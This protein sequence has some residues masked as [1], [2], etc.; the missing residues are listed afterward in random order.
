M[1]QQKQNPNQKRKKKKGHTPA[2][3]NTFAFRHNAKSK[4][5]AKI[6]ASPNEGV[7]KRCY[8]KIEW[9]KQYRKYKPLTQPATCNLCKKRNITA[10][11]HT[12]CG[13]CAVSDSAWQNMMQHMDNERNEAASSAV[14]NPYGTT[15]TDIDESS[16]IQGETASKP[17]SP[18]LDSKVPMVPTRKVVRGVVCAM[19]TKAP[20]MQD[21]N[22]QQDVENE[23]QEQIALMEEKLNRPLK[24][25][26]TKAIERKVIRAHEREKERLKEERRRAREEAEKED[27]IADDNHEQSKDQGRNGNPNLIVEKGDNLEESIA[28]D[29]DVEDEDDID[30]FLKAIGG[31]H[32]L[33][34]GEAYQQMILEQERLAKM[35]ISH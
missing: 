34:T 29:I 25:R 28:G 31:Q 22:K 24:L 19:C 20:A 35:Q 10:A 6:L 27:E 7:C 21:N 5:T 23:I 17:Q 13:S 9:R 8:D 12:I 4:L 11:Y 33:V 14:T 1:P 16:S 2:H 32:K 18:L 15:N 30:P 3:Q 26:E